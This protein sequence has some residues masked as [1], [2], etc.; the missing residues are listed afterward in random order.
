VPADDNCDAPHLDGT[1]DGKEAPGGP[2]GW[3]RVIA[4]KD[5]PAMIRGIGNAVTEEG[6]ALASLSEVPFKAHW[7]L[8]FYGEHGVEH[9]L[10]TLD[11][12]QKDG[13][14]DEASAGKI[15]RRLEPAKAI[16]SRLKKKLLGDPNPDAK[17]VKSMKQEIENALD[18]KRGALAIVEE[19]LLALS[20]SPIQA[21][22]VEA[23]RA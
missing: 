16:D 3:G 23:D 8:L 12:A 21:S 10:D 17:T 22:F 9:T 6:R 1:L 7:E 15:R 14:I 18:L 13:T 19:V 2:C 20:I 4:A 5:A 11:E